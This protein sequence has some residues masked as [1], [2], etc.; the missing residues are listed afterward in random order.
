[1]VCAAIEK[2]KMMETNSWQNAISGKIEVRV[3][4]RASSERVIAESLPGGGWRLKVYVTCAAEDGKANAAVVTLLAKTLGLPKSAITI[5]R[6][7]TGRLKTLD[8]Q[9]T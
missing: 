1:M 3:T 6:G 7:Q 9:R 5:L 8:I 2:Y 4:P